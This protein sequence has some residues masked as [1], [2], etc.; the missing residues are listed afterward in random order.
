M[1]SSS[2]LP[3]SPRELRGTDPNIKDA[4]AYHNSGTAHADQKMKAQVCAKLQTK[5]QVKGRR[6]LNRKCTLLGNSG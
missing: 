5:I 2:G 6:V 3:N 4:L 1:A